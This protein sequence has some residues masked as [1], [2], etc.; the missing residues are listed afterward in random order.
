[1][2]FN[3]PIIAALALI[4]GACGQQGLQDKAISIAVGEPINSA[5]SGA[6][7]TKR[8][9]PLL[10]AGIGPALDVQL[11]K[12]GVRGGFLLEAKQGNIESW[13]GNDG[14]A[15]IFDRGVLHSTRG[16]GAGILASDVSASANAVLSGQSGQIER[17]HT[18]LNGD[19][20][21]ETRAYICTVTNQGSETIQLDNGA[22]ATRK[23][24]EDCRNLDQEFT[25]VY[26]VDTGRGKIVRSRQWTGDF[27]GE[28]VINTVYNF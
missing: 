18:F 6:G 28:I 26:W 10:Q 27:A 14:V 3:T 19:N 11:P 1:M 17:V 20:R 15:L 16:I 25:N 21:A 13:L 12:F 8:F 22:T 9:Q 4:V 24:T 7:A 5:S 23:M 2:K